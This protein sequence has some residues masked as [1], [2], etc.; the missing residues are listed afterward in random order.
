MS[1]SAHVGITRGD[2]LIGALVA[3]SVHVGLGVGLWLTPADSAGVVAEA[4]PLADGCSAVVSPACVGLGVAPTPT[5][6][7]ESPRRAVEDRRCPEPIR[8]LLRRDPESPPAVAVDL[9]Q[10]ELVAALGVETGTRN[11]PKAVAQRVEAPK[12]KLVEAIGDNSKLGDMLKESGD[13]DAKKKKLGDILGR[14]DGKVGGEGKVNMPGSAYVREVKIAVTRSFSLPAS[15]PPW[16][17][18]DLMAK[19][20]VTRMTAGGGVLEWRFDKASG[21]EDFDGAVRSL[22][23]GYKSGLRT[24]P[25]PPPH[26]LEEINSRGFV[27]E[28]RG[29][30]G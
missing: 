28:L 7:Q 18:A 8:R 26:I 19:V 21:N 15:L 10:A 27:I 29:G 25:E 13:S 1:L 12:P 6:S 20:R 17:A 3:A 23:N 4:D 9:L 30:K 2:L 14:P 5:A 24:L 11:E 22:M 16:E